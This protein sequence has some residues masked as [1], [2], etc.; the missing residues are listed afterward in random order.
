MKIAA[1]IHSLQ[2]QII[3]WIELLIGTGDG[4][5]IVEY[6]LKGLFFGVL[7]AHRDVVEY[8]AQTGFVRNRD[9]LDVPVVV[10]VIQSH[11]QFAVADPFF[12]TV[13]YGNV[14]DD[15]VADIVPVD[16]AQG[17][18]LSLIHI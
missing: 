14:D 4:K 3:L 10:V 13:C 2:Q 1:A 11:C 5:T 17:L 18:I 6:Q 7:A 12:Q 16:K 8:Y 15:P 9:R